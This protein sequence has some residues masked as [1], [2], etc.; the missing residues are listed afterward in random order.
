MAYG[1][2]FWATQQPSKATQ[3]EDV[4]RRVLQGVDI[5]QQHAPRNINSDTLVTFNGEGQEYFGMDRTMLSKHLLMLGG[6]GTGKSNTFYH[7]V[8][9]YLRRLGER[10]ILVIFDTK[11][12]FYRQFYNERDSR[13]VLI[14][15]SPRYQ[16]ISRQWNVFDEL[17]DPDGRFTANSEL[18]AAEVA[19]GLFSN[20]KSE[21][22]PFFQIAAADLV[23]KAMIFQM[24]RYNASRKRGEPMEEPTT[25]LLASFLRSASIDTWRSMLSNKSCPDFRS[26]LSYIGAAG[27]STAQALGV[28]GYISAMANSLLVGVF[29]GEGAGRGRS[30][31]M[32]QLLRRRQGTVVFLEYDLEM[33]QVLS[34]MYK[35]LIDLALKEAL[36]NRMDKQNTGNVFLVIDEFKLL[37]NLQHIDDALNFGRSLGVKVCAGIQSINQLYDEYGEHRGRA[38]ASGFMNSFCFQTWDG[39]SRAYISERFGQSY[40]TRS[41]QGNEVQ[42]EGHVV[43]DW[44]ILGLRVGEAFVNLSADPP[45]PPFRFRFDLFETR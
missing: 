29:G 21:T 22:Q 12:D 33:G 41:I 31:A 32:R 17:K 25:R 19:R 6:V 4:F 36:A 28:L 42:R 23:A 37:P 38:L 26:S 30:F 13:H 27:N 10:D 5:R 20:L 11:G 44:D 8:S 39:D 34:P 9:Q 15:N 2:D 1:S 45:I 3:Q 24:R 35:V 16:R 7:I 40:E 18:L 14:G 43:S